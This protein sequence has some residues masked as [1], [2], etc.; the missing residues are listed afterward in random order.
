MTK[1]TGVRMQNKKKIKKALKKQLKKELK[2]IEKMNEEKI[3]GIDVG[4]SHTKVYTED[5]SD[6]FRST[7]KDGSIDINTKSTVIKFE[8]KTLTIGER[9]R[10]TVEQNKINDINFEP[11]LMTAI[12][13]NADLDK[14][15]MTDINVKIVTGLPI[16]WYPKQKDKLRDFLYNKKI[17]IGYKGVD[18]NIHI[19][20]CLV[21]PQSAGL[22]L[23]HPEEFSGNKTNLVV[24]IG[25][26]TVDVTLYEGKRIVKFASYQKGMMV[27]YSKIASAINGDYN[28]EVD[29]QD[30]EKFIED[31]GLTIN[32]ERI[33]YDFEKHFK[34]H[35]DEIV[36]S[37]KTGF[38]YDIVDKKTFIGGGSL[39][40]KD[41]LPS[42]K[43][44]K[45]DKIINNAQAFYNV[46][47]QKF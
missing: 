31:G 33:D 13:R 26:L 42:N 19:K 43:G 40:L 46:G 36:Q 16:A 17:T 8:G 23:T 27:L 24:D 45:C 2:G 18:R 28:I 34:Q 41:V 6:V 10:I 29:D 47:V 1:K 38:P 14:N 30:V 20:D 25:G 21:F 4:Y 35:M 32:E 15:D 7:V 12:L 5:G 39:R 9:G 11:L 44:I 3:M 37:I 22:P